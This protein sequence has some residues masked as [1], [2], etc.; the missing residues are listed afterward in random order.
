MKIE[1]SFKSLYKPVFVHT[2]ARA[3]KSYGYVH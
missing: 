3:L 2:V 1:Y